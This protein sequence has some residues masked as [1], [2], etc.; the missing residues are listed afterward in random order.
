[1]MLN[2]F[3]HRRW[4]RLVDEAAAGE[5]A[6]G[7]LARLERHL[8]SCRECRDELEQLRSVRSLLGSLEAPPLPRPF[9]LAPAALSQA[10]APR[11]RLMF[12]TAMLAAQGLALVGAV[13]FGVLLTLS[14]TQHES[15]P[16]ASGESAPA[17]V[18]QHAPET[19]A[20]GTVGIAAETPAPGSPSQAV[21][22]PA[23][24]ETAVPEPSDVSA[25]GHAT[26]TEGGYVGP[27]VT[28]ESRVAERTP[29]SGAVP[30]QKDT[31]APQ[32]PVHDHRIEASPEAPSALAAPK[33]STERGFDPLPYAIAA[34]VV[35]VAAMVLTFTLRRR[36]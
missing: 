21:T 27:P 14:V 11:P 20:P 18:P 29:G 6:G 15:S 25:A 26:P 2:P 17:A 10:A 13:A 5:L 24:G 19:A 35:T 16:A 22:P 9:T 7:K 4:R 3:S 32:T 31:G 33:A 1:M 8:A 36:T 30:V 34:G 28:P 23:T 12:R